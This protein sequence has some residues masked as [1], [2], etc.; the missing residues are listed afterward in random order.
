MVA[1]PAA[2]AK[3]PLNS[4]TIVESAGLPGQ[5]H[6]FERGDAVPSIRAQKSWAIR[7]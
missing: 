4:S 1:A 5:H 6:V 3:S 2:A 7:D